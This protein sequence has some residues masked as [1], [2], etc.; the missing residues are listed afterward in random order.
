M[1]LLSKDRNFYHVVRGDEHGISWRSLL[2][3]KNILSPRDQI[4]RKTRFCDLVL[5]YHGI[6]IN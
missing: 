1:T 2:K 5:A 6:V 4:R 3:E